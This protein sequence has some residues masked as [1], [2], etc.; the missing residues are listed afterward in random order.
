MTADLVTAHSFHDPIVEMAPLTAE[1]T[2]R[3]SVVPTSYPTMMIAN[4]IQAIDIFCLSIANYV[5][6]KVQAV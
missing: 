2:G 4:S 3:S 6:R 1:V 5:L